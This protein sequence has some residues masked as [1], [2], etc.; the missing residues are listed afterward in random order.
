MG[1]TVLWCRV[2]EGGRKAAYSLH[3]RRVQDHTPAR[4]SS[5]NKLSSPAVTY[6]PSM[7]GSHVDFDRD[8]MVD[9]MNVDIQFFGIALESRQTLLGA[10]EQMPRDVLNRLSRI[11]TSAA[12]LFGVH[13]C[14]IFQSRLIL[15]ASDGRYHH[16][17]R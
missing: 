15:F 10:L 14:R 17:S 6:V 11:S 5:E 3:K 1:K 13:A 16:L 8:M 12:Q 4:L 9:T 7:T 2:H